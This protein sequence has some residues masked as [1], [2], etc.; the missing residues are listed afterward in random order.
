MAL[1]Q[2]DVLAALEVAVALNEVLELS[3]TLTATPVC[4]SAAGMSVRAKPEQLA[5]A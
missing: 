1:E 5:F 4:R 2:A 3:A